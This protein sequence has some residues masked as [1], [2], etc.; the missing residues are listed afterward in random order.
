MALKRVHVELP[1]AGAVFEILGQEG[2]YWEDCMI[3]GKDFG[4]FPS[5]YDAMVHY[6]AALVSRKAIKSLGQLI[7][8]DFKLKKVV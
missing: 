2:Y 3:P 7:Q 1:K 6:K 8:V 5:I 4:P